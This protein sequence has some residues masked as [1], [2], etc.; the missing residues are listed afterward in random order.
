MKGTVVDRK[1]FAEMMSEYYELRG[2]DRAG[3]QKK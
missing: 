2:W 1:K 3:L